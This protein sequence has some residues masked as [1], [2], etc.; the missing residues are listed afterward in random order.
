MV[1]SDSEAGAGSCQGIHCQG[2]YYLGTRSLDNQAGNVPVGLESASGESCQSQ[3]QGQFL[4]EEAPN[5]ED[6]SQDSNQIHHYWTGLMEFAGPKHHKEL[7]RVDTEIA[8]VRM[9]RWPAHIARRHDSCQQ[10]V[11]L[12]MSSENVGTRFSDSRRDSVQSAGP[13]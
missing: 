9:V 13:A 10:I 8:T 3:Y 5:E 12:A 11:Q 6:K 7:H 4:L 2:N 1:G